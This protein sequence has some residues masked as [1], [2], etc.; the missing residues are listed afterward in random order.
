MLSEMVYLDSRDKTLGDEIRKIIFKLKPLV[1]VGKPIDQDDLIQLHRLTHQIPIDDNPKPKDAK[2]QEAQKQ[3]I[4]DD[5]V[6]L[7]KTTDH[8]AVLYIIDDL[9]GHYIELTS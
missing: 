3:A 4:L 2:W 1:L 9:F 8:S 5:I 6:S 7:T